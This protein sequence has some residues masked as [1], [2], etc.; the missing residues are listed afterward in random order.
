MEAGSQALA[1]VL[2]DFTTILA[3]M[4]FNDYLERLQ[5]YKISTNTLTLRLNGILVVGH[6]GL[7]Q[8]YIFVFPHFNFSVQFAH[9]VRLSMCVQQSHH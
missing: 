5:C 7:Y 2:P 3:L 8:Y 6:K 9:T 4:S 1:T